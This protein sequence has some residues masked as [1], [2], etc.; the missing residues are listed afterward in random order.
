MYRQQQARNNMAAEETQFLTCVSSLPVVNSAW[1]QVSDMYTKTKEYNSLFN[2]TL[3]I[4]E[5]SVIKVV[6]TAQPLAEKYEGQIK[7]VNA[8]ACNQLNHLKEN[9]PVIAKPTDQMIKDGKEKCTALIQPAVDRITAVKDFGV[10]AYTKGTETV[11]TATDYSKNQLAKVTNYG[12]DVVS[13]ALQTSY[14]QV[15]NA[16]VIDVL[17]MSEVYLDKYLPPTEKEVKE[18]AKDSKNAL[19]RAGHVG[20]K[21][22]RRMYNR[23]M[24]DLHNVKVRSTETLNKLNFT[25]DLIQY[26]KTNLD[27]AKT[28]V[29]ETVT[30]ANAKFWDTWDEINREEMEGEKEEVEKQ[31]LEKRGIVVARHLVRQLKTGLNSLETTMVELPGTLQEKYQGL[32]KYTDD[33]WMSFKEVGSIN[34]VPMWVINQTKNQL[35]YVQEMLSFLTEQTL[36]ALPLGW[37]EMDVNLD[38]LNLQEIE[39]MWTHN[40]NILSINGRINGHLDG[41]QEEQ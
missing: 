34:E 32:Q 14:G 1:T 3:G 37:M 25:V 29:G 35:S 26:A 24:R 12:H 31:S 7:Y 18:L 13:Q 28:R 21:L 27:G 40:G 33:I 10:N 17:D 8:V 36:N 6:S 30:A 22:Q 41:G 15:V 19:E 39:H 16:K 9:Y 20:S 11:K 23:A 4:A 2:F 38:G 5:S